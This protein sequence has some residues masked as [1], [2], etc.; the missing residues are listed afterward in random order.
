[1]KLFQFQR[2]QVPLMV[3]N[4]HSGVFIPPEMAS[5][6]TSA[7]LEKRDTDWH[8]FRLYDVPELQR[9]G[10]IKANH[11]RYVIDLNRPASNENLYPGQETTG[12]CP[13][14][15]FN[16]EAIY[17]DRE[18]LS[19]SEIQK[20]VEHYW[21]PYH[22]Q[23][24]AELDRLT[25]NFGCV[26]LL[27]VHS[28]AEQV[29]MLFEGKIPDFSFGT[30]HGAS[31]GRSL[32]SAVE[33]FAGSIQHYSAVVNQRFI[34]GFITRHYGNKPGVEAVQLELNRSTYMDETTLQWDGTKASKVQ[35]V[36]RE[37]IRMLLHHAE[38]EYVDGEQGAKK[39]KR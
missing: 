39:Q 38:A 26:I 21:Q 8:L 36:I 7:G 35:P 17:R 28:I 27:D 20:R 13:L 10:M 15:T 24:E 11:S 12:L 34:G 33:S 9:A 3:S 30:N 32:Q 16:R 23:L 2:G 22:R 18:Q 37:F 1:M 31:C 6:M 14:I 29:P 5:A 25:E 19:E 4:P